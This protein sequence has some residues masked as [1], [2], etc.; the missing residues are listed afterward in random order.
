MTKGVKNINASTAPAQAA[1]SLPIPSG[2][3]IPTAHLSTKD[4]QNI[5]KI[6]AEWVKIQQ[7]QDDKVKLAERLERIVSRARERGRAEWRRVGGMDVDD[8]ELEIKAVTPEM[9]VPQITGNK[10]GKKATLPLAA[11]ISA[12]LGTLSGSHSPAGRAGSMPP[13]PVPRGGSQSQ[14]QSRANSR[15]RGRGHSL[16][17]S[18]EPE[19]EPEME[20]EVDIIDGAEVEADDQLYCFCQQ[21][22]FGEMIGCDNDKCKYEWVRATCQPS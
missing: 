8:E 11:A 4:A 12:G 14:S 3:P 5:S 2:A 17:M 16:A 6:Q 13:P 18:V 9:V 22:S 20:T 19:P 15:G 7:L 21:K 1:F 10:R